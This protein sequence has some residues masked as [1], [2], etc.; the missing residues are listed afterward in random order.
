MGG[1]SSAKTGKAAL[2]IINSGKQNNKYLIF[3][4][5]LPVSAAPDLCRLS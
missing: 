5:G 1:E 3:T 2:E 4:P